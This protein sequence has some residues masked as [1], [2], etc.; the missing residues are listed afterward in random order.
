MAR[1]HAIKALETGIEVIYS[2]VSK[3]LDIV[4][5]GDMGIGNTTPSS[6]ICAVM[7]KRP[8]SEVT[9]RGTGITDE[10]LKHKIDVVE[11][12][13]AVNRPTLPTQ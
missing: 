3:G 12:A 8:V 5:T 10:Q 1:E 2:E 4:G 6:A 11:R 7:M 9:G 13:I